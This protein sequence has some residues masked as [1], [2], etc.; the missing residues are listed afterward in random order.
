LAAH[1]YLYRSSPFVPGQREIV[2]TANYIVLYEVDD[3]R[4]RVTVTNVAHSRMKH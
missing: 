2:V 3:A 4:R 1:P